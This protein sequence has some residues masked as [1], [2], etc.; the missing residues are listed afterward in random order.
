MMGEYLFYPSQVSQIIQAI[1]FSLSLAFN[2]LALCA[3]LYK[4]SLY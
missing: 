1:N 2:Q 3:I 4:S